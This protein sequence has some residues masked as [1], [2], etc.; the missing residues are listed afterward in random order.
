MFKWSSLCCKII[1]HTYFSHNSNIEYVYLTIKFINF[2]LINYVIDF[3]IVSLYII[4]SD[5]DFMFL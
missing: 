5:F 2:E 3:D 1:N 4:F